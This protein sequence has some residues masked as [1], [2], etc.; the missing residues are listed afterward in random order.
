MTVL[1]VEYILGQAMTTHAEFY[2]ELHALLGNKTVYQWTSMLVY[3]P[4]KPI[5]I[6][7]HLCPF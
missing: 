7:T 4:Y 5:G 1:L 3:W 6:G 2:M